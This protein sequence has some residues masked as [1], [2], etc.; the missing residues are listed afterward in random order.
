MIEPLPYTVMQTIQDD[1]APPGRRSYWKAGYLKGL[2]DEAIEAAV[3][4][5]A[6]VPSPFSLAEIVL[7]GGAVA[8]VGNDETAFGNRQAPFLFNIVSMWEDGSDDDANIGWAREYF[9]ALEPHADD[10]VYVNFLSEE[11]DARVRAAY[12]DEKYARLASLKAKY[13]PDNFF[14]LNQ[15]INPGG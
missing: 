3:S 9:A 15:N 10:G 8:S 7:W 11:G 1:L 6:K 14:R 4:V 12:G 5:A 2:T 13:D